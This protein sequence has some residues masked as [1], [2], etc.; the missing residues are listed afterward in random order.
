MTSMAVQRKALLNSLSGCSKNFDIVRLITQEGELLQLRGRYSKRPEIGV[1]LQMENPKARR[2]S[3][4]VIG[5]FD[6]DS[7]KSALASISS[8]SV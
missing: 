5:P 8:Y 1:V 7:S 2:V 3:G 6:I 4:P